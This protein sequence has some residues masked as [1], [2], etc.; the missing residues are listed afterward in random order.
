MNVASFAPSRPRI[1]TIGE[2]IDGAAGRGAFGGAS[3][4][5]RRSARPAERHAPLVKHAARDSLFIA[6]QPEEEMSRVDELLAE[7]LRLRERVFEDDLAARRE[8][9]L[10]V[11]LRRRSGTHDLLDRFAQRSV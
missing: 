7:S 4:A 6:D 5:M 8:R 10:T 2:G 1:S 11:V 3:S 9:K